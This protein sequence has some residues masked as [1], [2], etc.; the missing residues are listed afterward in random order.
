MDPTFLFI[1]TIIELVAKYGVPGVLAI[2]K[3]WETDYS[4]ITRDDIERLRHMVPKPDAD[5]EEVNN[6]G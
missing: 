4:H 1:I 5:I 2:I 6:G 3:E